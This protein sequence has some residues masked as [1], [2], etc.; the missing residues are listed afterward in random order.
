MI[1]NNK[2][3]TI[4]KS[5]RIEFLKSIEKLNASENNDLLKQIM[6]ESINSQIETF[7]REL[8]EYEKLK[9]EKPNIIST[10]I[11]KLPETLIK[12]RI[13]KGLSQYELAEKAGLKEQQIQRYES[14]NYESANFERIMC[15]AKSM[16]IHFEET[17]VFLNSEIMEVEGIDPVFLRQATSR[18]QSTR[19]LFTV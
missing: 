14:N 11:E 18:L 4:T 19:S 10:Q 5:R 13:A 8:L 7:D 12:A 17:K 3:Y 1:K 16:N 15:V 9:N 6:I 2:Q